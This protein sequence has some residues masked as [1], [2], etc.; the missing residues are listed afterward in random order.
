MMTASSTVLA[1]DAAQVRLGERVFG[2]FSVQLSPGER[3]AILGPSGAGK[4]TLLK[5]MSGEVRHQRGEIRL[6][7][8]DLRSRSMSGLAMRRAVLPQSHEVAFGLPAELVIRLGRAARLRDAGVDRII[9]LAATLAQA[10]HLLEAR[11]DSLSGGERARVQLA[12]I[13][14]QM[15]DVA[16]G[17]IFVDEPLAALDPGLQLHLAS[18]IDAFARARNHAV[19]AV[20][21]DLNHALARFDRLLLVKDCQQAGL[22]NADIKAIP[23]LE[24]LYGIRLHHTQVS[25]RPVVMSVGLQAA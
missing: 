14:A 25:G 22:L 21:H 13:F 17:V 4:S 8:R 11:F 24:Q 19:V 2:P 20:I 9:Y 10:E 12:R 15:W 18:A 6:D 16:A 5:L 1:L 23:A 7:G 3:L